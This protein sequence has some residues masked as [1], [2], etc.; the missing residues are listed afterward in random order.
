[1]AHQLSK[2]TF[3]RGVKCEKNLY[4]NK[5]HKDLRDETS[6]Q[7]AAIFSQGSKV[8]ELAQA[9]FPGGIDLTPDTFY[10][11]DKS[12][13][14]T[15]QAIKRGEKVIYEAAFLFNGVLAAMDILVKTVNG[16]KAYEVKSST[17]VKDVYIQ[18]VALQTYVIQNCGV[19]LEDVSVIFINSQY[20]KNGPVDINELFNIVS[21][22]ETI[23]NPLAAVPNQV[24]RFTEVLKS[25]QIPEIPIGN[26]CTAPYGC[27]FMG[28]CWRDIPAYSVF[29]ISRLKHEKSMQLYDQG[30][31]KLEDV[32]DEFPLSDNQRAQVEAEKNKTEIIDQTAITAFLDGLNYPLYH[33][34]FETMA[35]AIPIFDGSRPY[36]QIVFQYSLHI[37]DYPN[38]VPTHFEYLGETNGEDPRI[39]FVDQLISDLNEE[40]DILV[41]NIVFEKGKLMD[42]AFLF[43]NRANELNAIINRL[44]DLMEPFQ[45]KW[46]YNYKMKGSYSIKKV[47]PALVP[48]FDDSYSSLTI[49]DGGTASSVYAQMTDGSYVGDY[50]SAHKDLLAYCKLDTLAMVKI[51]G[52]LYSL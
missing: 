15:Q 41:Y 1:M 25:T 33:L 36:Q 23:Q 28:Q 10:D 42:L 46:C 27:D 7:Q 38:A 30:I 32:P 8:G 37:Q 34:D 35:H 4:L 26:H 24:N 48:E 13:Y 40:G 3:M 22:W 44:K 29:N 39:K 5:H 18:D 19:N 51:L 21:I 45:K 20:V 12:I 16:Y 43:S 47:L 14:D 2:S 31:L 6:L 11:F 50:A 52:Y 17:G 9:L 49:S